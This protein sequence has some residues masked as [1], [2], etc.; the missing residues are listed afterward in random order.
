MAKCSLLF[1]FFLQGLPLALG[2][3]RA[4]VPWRHRVQ[5][6]TNGQV[7]SLMSTG[8]EFQAPARSRAQSRFY[9]S[10]RKD[11]TSS[12]AGHSESRTVQPGRT[13]GQPPGD[14]RAS[15]SAQQPERPFGAGA[16]MNSS[17]V[18]TLTDGRREAVYRVV[19]GGEEPGLGARN[20]PLRAVP[21]GMLVSRQPA[22]TD[23][24]IPLYQTEPGALA[25]LPA[26]SVDVSNE[27]DEVGMVNDDPRH[28]F[29][30]HRNSVF[31]NMY[32]SRGAPVARTPG[33]GYGTR[34]FQNG[35]WSSLSSRLKN[36]TRVV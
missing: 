18:G 19:T 24:F 11:G 12:R 22:Q 10:S 17:A 25:A 33:S 26:L 5:W 31:Y 8:S 16:R 15:G 23:Q 1:I 35:E 30:N 4:A 9:V 21:A 7:Y 36:N 28:P 29:K 6:A 20:H 27:A 14:G 3:Q 32:P 13:A 34:Y 2:Q